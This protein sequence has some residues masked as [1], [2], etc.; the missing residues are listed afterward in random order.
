[1]FK[2]KI[3]LFIVLI[4]FGAITQVAKA[5]KV[6]GFNKLGFDTESQLWKIAANCSGSKKPRILVSKDKDGPWCAEQ[7]PSSCEKDTLRALNKVC[8]GF[9]KRDLDR[10][11]EEQKVI[12]QK[13]AEERRVALLAELEKVQQ[14][15][16]A[17]NERKDFVNARIQQLTQRNAELEQQISSL[18]QN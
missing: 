5:S 7:L 1:M 10:Y 17:I 2:S 6:T 13:E 4:A 8:S 11:L 9:F 18:P 16:K 12:K 15:K 14:S 3:F